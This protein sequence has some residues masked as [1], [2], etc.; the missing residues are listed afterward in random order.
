MEHAMREKIRPLSIW[1]VGILVL[2]V[3]VA[4]TGLVLRSR[5]GDSTTKAGETASPGANPGGVVVCFGHVD[6]EPG[7]TALYPVRPG[8]VSEVLV[9]EDDSVKAGTVLFRIDDRPAR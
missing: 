4:G 1:C 9:H 7:V 8:R 5:A 6:V 2:A 3:S